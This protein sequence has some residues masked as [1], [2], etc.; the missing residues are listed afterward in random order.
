MYIL[1]TV[2]SEFFRELYFRELGQTN[3]KGV[4]GNGTE[5]FRQGRRTCLFLLVF[6]F[7]K[8][9]ILCIL[10]GEMPVKMHNIIFFPGKPEK[11]LG[12]TSSFM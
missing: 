2:N 8:N 9:I 3:N 4:S 11:N 1:N 10:K 12:F 6:F 7:W 5:N